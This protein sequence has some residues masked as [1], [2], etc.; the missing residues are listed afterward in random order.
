MNIDD[1]SDQRESEI[2]TNKRNIS[3]KN[4]KRRKDLTF[5]L[6]EIMNVST[7]DYIREIELRYFDDER[8]KALDYIK[9]IS[10]CSMCHSDAQNS[11]ERHD[12]LD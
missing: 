1:L 7:N 11:L 3:Q 8:H 9:S 5:N 12:A 4:A 2:N 6:W 10:C